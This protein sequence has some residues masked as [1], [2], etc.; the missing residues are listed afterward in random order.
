MNTKPVEELSKHTRQQY[1]CARKSFEDAMH[2]KVE[3]ATQQDIESWLHILRMRGCAGNTC[4]AYLAIVLRI[5]GLRYTLPPKEKVTRHLS[6]DEIKKLLAASKGNYSWLA[7]LLIAGPEVLAWKWGWLYDAKHALPMSAY[8]VIVAEAQRRK[9]DTFPFNYYGRPAHW[10]NPNAMNPA[11]SIWNIA[12]HEINRRL[13]GIARTAGISDVNMN[14]TTMRYAHESLLERHGHA[15]KAA[16][17]LGI[18]PAKETQNPP[19]PKADPRLH[20]I[21]RRSNF[22]MKSA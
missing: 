16:K 9:M 5:S 8:F 18:D 10:V 21:G 4:R 7:S 15:D 14:I 13:K 6:D 2:K 17:A 19:A 1:T 3:K 22:S 11:E 20:G 12:P